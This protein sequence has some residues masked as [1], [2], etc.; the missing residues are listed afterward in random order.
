[1]SCY[2]VEVNEEFPSKAK[3]IST[4]LVYTCL[5][6][7]SVYAKNLGLSNFFCIHFKQFLKLLRSVIFTTSYGGFLS[8]KTINFYQ[9]LFNREGLTLGKSRSSHR[10]CSLKKVVLKN[11]I[12]LTGKLLYWSLFFN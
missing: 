4:S 1:M 9:V 3:S 6:F 5:P 8:S 10:R 7:L 12:K 2:R 11:F